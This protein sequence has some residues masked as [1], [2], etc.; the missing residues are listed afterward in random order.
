MG[1]T[2]MFYALATMPEFFVARLSLF[3]A[4]APV[5]TVSS[6]RVSLLKFLFI[7]RDDLLVFLNLF[8]VDQLLY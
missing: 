6:H 5:T 8:K 3:V 2:Q 7:Y 4:L 1:T